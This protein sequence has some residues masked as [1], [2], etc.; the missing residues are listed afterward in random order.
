MPY[1]AKENRERYVGA[2]N[3]ILSAL[4]EN[5]ADAAGEFTYVIYKLLER[6]NG[7]YWERALGIGSVVM[8]IHEMYRRE[9]IQ[10]EDKKI[11]EHGDV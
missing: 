2:I 11:A 1:I 6:F 4:P 10:Y 7:R 3:D 8:A 5:S 9:H